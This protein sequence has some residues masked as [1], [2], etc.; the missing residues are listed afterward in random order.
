MPSATPGSPH[1]PSW[2]DTKVLHSRKPE[3]KRLWTWGYKKAG[4]DIR[5]EL[6]WRSVYFRVRPPSPCHPLTSQNTD[7]QAYIPIPRKLEEPSVVKWASS[8][9]DTSG[10]GINLTNELKDLYTK[11][12]KT[13]INWL[14]KVLKNKIPLGTN[15]Y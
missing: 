9:E 14:K 13:L 3:C 15:N 7:N 4:Y 1:L 6:E 5:Q 2:Q 11:N 12:Y 8:K 10:L